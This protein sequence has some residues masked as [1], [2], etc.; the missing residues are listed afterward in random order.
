MAAP[1]NLRS[2]NVLKIGNST[3]KELEEKVKAF[4]TINLNVRKRRFIIARENITDNSGNIIVKKGE[5]IDLSKVMLLKRHFRQDQAI[6]TFQPDEGIVI[7][8][9]MSSPQGIQFS[10]DIV[11]QV[12]NIGGGAYEA[13]IDRVDS[14]KEL[15]G[16]Y[17][18][19]LF[20]R[21]VLIG[22]VAADKVQEEMAGFHV[23]SKADPYIRML[24]IVHSTLKTTQVIPRI[25][26][27]PIQQ[28]DRDSWKRFIVE[29]IQEYTKPYS[30]EE[31]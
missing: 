11:T 1:E 23:I 19:A 22:F 9:D 5:D 13:F 31:R 10:M 6:K 27:I 24:E 17:N 3:L 8:S 15:L 16:L 12:M 2:S 7:I 14:F 25:R 29:I 4:R 21:M 18:K 28:D 30:I 20:P 26:A